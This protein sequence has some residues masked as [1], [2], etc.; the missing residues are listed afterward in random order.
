MAS[1]VIHDKNLFVP[2]R[3]TQ[4][5]HHTLISH[6]VTHSILS[7]NCRG[8]TLRIHY[9]SHLICRSF[10]ISNEFTFFVIGKLRYMDYDVE[11]V[12]HP[13]KVYEQFYPRFPSVFTSRFLTFTRSASLN[14]VL[15]KASQ[16]RIF[17]H[18]PF[19]SEMIM[20][21]KQT[22]LFRLPTKFHFSRRIVTGS[23][24]FISSF[25]SSLSWVVGCCQ[26][27]LVLRVISSLRFCWLSLVSVQIFWSLSLRPWR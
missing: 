25:C 7:L 10:V 19:Y 5:V 16:S 24:Y 1:L 8:L 27:R 21:F 18:V 26:K 4:S 20:I 14:L 3:I 2:L 23:I 22:C 9:L 13:N 12:Y 15:A 6:K 17:N 11:P